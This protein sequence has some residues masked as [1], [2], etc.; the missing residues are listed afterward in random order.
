MAS[1]LVDA[2]AHGGVVELLAIHLF[3]LDL[4]FR[5]QYFVECGNFD[6]VVNKEGLLQQDG[7]EYFLY[8]LPE[9]AQFENLVI[10]PSVALFFS[11]RLHF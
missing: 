1:A 6:F 7:R 9:G 3:R 2:G 8:D 10:N 4:V 11:A 5:E